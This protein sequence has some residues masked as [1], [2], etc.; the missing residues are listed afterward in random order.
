MWC[1]SKE[2]IENIRVFCRLRSATP[3][4]EKS[5]RNCIRVENSIND[6]GECTVVL[7]QLDDEEHRYRF[8]HVQLSSFIIIFILE[9]L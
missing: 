5:G 3:A 1:T 8:P 2:K 4:E 7:K 9:Y 6:G